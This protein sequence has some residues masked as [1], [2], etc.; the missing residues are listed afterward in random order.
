MLLDLGEEKTH[1]QAQ[2]QA[3]YQLPSHT[4]LARMQTLAPNVRANLVFEGHRKAMNC[5]LPLFI[6]SDNPQGVLPSIKDVPLESP[7]ERQGRS[8]KARDDDQLNDTPL[9]PSLRVFTYRNT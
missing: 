9:L 8:R 5:P 6:P 3:L 1:I 7:Q 2:L 4:P